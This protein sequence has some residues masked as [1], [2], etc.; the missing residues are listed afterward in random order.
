MQMT[1]LRFLKDRLRAGGSDTAD[2]EL[3]ILLEDVVGLSGGALYESEIPL[4]P[5]IEQKLIGIIDR[6]LQ[7]EP[8]G[9]ILGY[10]DFWKNRFYLS[11]DT[12]EPR[13]DTEILIE[14]A[15]SGPPARRILDLGTGSGCILVTL[16]EEWPA[17]FGV[18]V[19][20]ASGACEVAQENAKKIGVAERVTF[21]CGDWLSPVEGRFDLIVSNPPYIPSADIPN[22]DENVRNF[23]P[24]LA[25]DGGK[26]GL[27]PYKYLLPRLKNFLEP[28]GR[29]LFE[30]G[31]GQGEDILRL[32]KACGA[33]LSRVVPDLRGI[34]RVVEI[35]YGDN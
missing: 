34:P 26:E 32:V 2:F 31:Q 29:V 7:G 6:R 5:E 21:L 23:D 28:H 18:G 16:L 1:S 12:L 30:I 14:T 35:S 33:N 22:L 27:D 10:R 17:A 4:S 25:L 19:D 9:R 20:K 13:P 8:L 11:P 15:L 24:I 3:K